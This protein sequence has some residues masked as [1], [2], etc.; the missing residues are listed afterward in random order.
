MIENYAKI[1]TALN[2]T[3]E[4][5]SEHIREIAKNQYRKEKNMPYDE[6]DCIYYINGIFC[7]LENTTCYICKDKILLKEKEKL[8]I[9]EKYTLTRKNG[10]IIKENKKTEITKTK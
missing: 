2:L 8:E 9:I 10:K 3:D 6:K 1:V 7:E 4:Q 5:I